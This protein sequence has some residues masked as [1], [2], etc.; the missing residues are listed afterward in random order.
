MRLLQLQKDGGLRLTEHNPNG[1]PPYAILSHRWGR[2]QD[3]VTF[4]D[5]TENTG[6]DKL[7]YRKVLSCGTQ[8]ARDGLFF[9]W[10]RKLPFANWKYKEKH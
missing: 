10:V 8:A 6:R 1:I 2:D 4:Q 3:E 7:G 9:F 5:L